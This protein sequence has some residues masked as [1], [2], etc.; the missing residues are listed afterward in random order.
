MRF[1]RLVVIREDKRKDWR[2]CYLMKC[3]CWNEKVIRAIHLWTKTATNSC[4]C[5]RSELWRARWTKH[6]QTKTR[7]YETWHSMKLRCWLKTNDSYDRYWERGIRVCDR[8][9]DSFENFYSDMWERPKGMTLERINNDWNYEPWNC[10][11]AT[12]LEQ[13]RNKRNNIV[14]ELNWEKKTMSDW[15]RITWIKVC[16]IWRRINK[17]WFTTEKALSKPVKS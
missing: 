1:W 10:R 16:T 5:L 2:K 7:E 13:G 4:W 6:W 15:A 12:P 11:W 8:W 14:L 3:D 17:Y 9:M